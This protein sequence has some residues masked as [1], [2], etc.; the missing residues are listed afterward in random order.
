LQVIDYGLLG[1]FVF[2]ILADFIFDQFIGF[3]TLLGIIGFLHFGRIT[4]AIENRPWFAGIA[5]ISLALG[6]FLTPVAFDRT[7][8]ILHQSRVESRCADWYTR[9]VLQGEKDASLT[10]SGRQDTNGDHQG[11]CSVF[12]HKGGETVPVAVVECEERLFFPNNCGL[13]SGTTKR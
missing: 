7:M 6:T 4:T 3:T 10:F 1:A 2:G 11:R 12:Q 9:E 5:A 8:I 13:A